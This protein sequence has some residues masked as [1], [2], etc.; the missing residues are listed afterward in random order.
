MNWLRTFFRTRS[1][2][3]AYPLVETCTMPYGYKQAIIALARHAYESMKTTNFADSR[4]CCTKVLVNP[5]ACAL[6]SFHKALAVVRRSTKSENL[7]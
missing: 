4:G 1:L 6:Y 2:Y 5:S 3:A 7:L